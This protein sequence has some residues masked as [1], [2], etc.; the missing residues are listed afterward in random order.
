MAEVQTHQY[1]NEIAT[2]LA[3]ERMERKLLR[4]TKR[5]LAYKGVRRGVKEVCKSLR[6]G[7]PGIVIFA[8]D[9]SPVDVIS[10]IPVKC[11]ENGVPYIF[12]H[13]RSELG[14]AAGTQRPTSVILLRDPP[15]DSELADAFAKLKARI[16]SKEPGDD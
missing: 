5:C 14:A 3:G 7:L 16:L 15:E 13:S 2:P 11:E 12:V 9:V 1:V 8:A 10:H 4:Q 6:K